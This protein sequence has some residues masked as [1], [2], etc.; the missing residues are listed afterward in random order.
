[1]YS[2]SRGGKQG[3]IEDVISC[4]EIS[5]TCFLFIL[6]DGMGGLS[7]GEQA[8][9]AIADVYKRQVPDTNPFGPWDCVGTFPGSTGWRIRIY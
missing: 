1:M 5:D 4:V 7:R 6:V 3:K 2:C 8:A 9:Q